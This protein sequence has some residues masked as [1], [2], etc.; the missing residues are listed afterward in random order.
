M[1]GEI[2]YFKITENNKQVSWKNMI[3]KRYFMEL[4]NDEQ[5]KIAFNGWIMNAKPMED[6]AMTGWHYLRR[7]INV[8]GDSAK[9]RY[10]NCPADS[11]YLWQHMSEYVSTMASVFDGFR[12]DNAHSTPIHV[13]YY[14][15]QIARSVNPNLFVMAELFTSS[16]EADAMF[17]RKLNIN[18]LIREMQNTY[19]A[20]NLG[21]Y[22]HA[23]TCREAVLGLLDE[24]FEDISTGEKYKILKSKRPLDILYDCTHDNPAPVKK[25][26]TGRIALP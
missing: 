10:G 4:K 5:S 25:F 16:A 9:L 18:G 22:F 6:F 2:R 7:T 19:D 15:L 20:K 12:L 21:D 24:D 26:K 17:V 23:M 14:M 1:E 8:W 3:V 11:P 13:C